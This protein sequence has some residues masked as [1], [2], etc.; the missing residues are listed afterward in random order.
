[1]LPLEG[2]FFLFYQ[3]LQVLGAAGPSFHQNWM[4]KKSL[5]FMKKSE[6]FHDTNTFKFSP[7]KK[8]GQLGPSKPWECESQ[9]VHPVKNEG[10]GGQR[11]KSIW[12]WGFTIGSD[13]VLL[14]C[15]WGLWWHG[16]RSWLWAS[17]DLGFSL[18]RWALVTWLLSL[19]GG[20]HDFEVRS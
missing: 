9:W 11:H 10:K 16:H 8:G 2:L 3:D 18:V 5:K 13:D 4:P 7:G 15:S 14:S 1:M 17:D 20:L 12:Q 6:K 19:S